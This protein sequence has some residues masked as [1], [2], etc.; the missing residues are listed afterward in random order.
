LARGGALVAGVEVSDAMIRLASHRNAAL[1]RAGT[2]ALHKGDGIGL[3]Q[4]EDAFDAVVS[5]HNIYFWPE[6]QRTLGEIS[7]VLRPGG[8]VVLAFRAGEHP[9]P[10]RLDPAVYR[11]VTTTQAVTWLEQVGFT[12]VTR[13]QPSGVSETLAFLT[14]T[15]T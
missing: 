2:L 4:P 10:R 1:V 8:R 6:P 12:D 13:H 7:R 15:A 14:G 5:V 3:P 9:L 11:S